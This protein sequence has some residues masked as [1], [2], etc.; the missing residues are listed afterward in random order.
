MAFEYRNLAR[1]GGD[2]VAPRRADTA[3]TFAEAS[4]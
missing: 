1:G 4:G 2:P 3:P